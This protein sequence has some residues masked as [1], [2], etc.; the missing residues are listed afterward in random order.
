MYHRFHSPSDSTIEYV[1]VIPGEIFNVNPITLKR[2]DNLF[3]KNERVVIQLR[4]HDTSEEI[5]LVAVGAILVG[6]VRLHCIDRTIKSTNRK[7][8]QFWPNKKISRGEE[9]GWFEHGST[10]LVFLNNSC[11]FERTITLNKILRMGNELANY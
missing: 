3:C 8:Y 4:T 10:I 9:L 1:K 7:C 5:I 11:E 6:S 2:K